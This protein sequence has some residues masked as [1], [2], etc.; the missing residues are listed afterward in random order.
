MS[1]AKGTRPY[2]SLQSERP[3][4]AS[5]QPNVR[6][7]VRG[8]RSVLSVLIVLESVLVP[9]RICYIAQRLVRSPGDKIGT[10]GG[11]FRRD[12]GTNSALRGTN[13]ARFPQGDKIGQGVRRGA[14]KPFRGTKSDS[15]KAHSNPLIWL[16]NVG[17]LKAR[18]EFAGDKNGAS[19]ARQRC[20]GRNRTVRMCRTAVAGDRIGPISGGRILFAC[21]LSVGQHERHA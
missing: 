19:L 18:I 3:S 21:P 4:K 10:C 7:L 11:H 17:P 8:I 14:K 5:K 6:W 2:L 16:T 13:S 1:R 15:F 20:G 12:R 9:I